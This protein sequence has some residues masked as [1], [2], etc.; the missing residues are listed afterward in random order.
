MNLDPSHTP[1]INVGSKGI[2]KINVEGKKTHEAN[3][4]KYETVSVN[5]G[6]RR[7]S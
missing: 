4:R 2:K 7:A 3:R 6:Y 5:L 1:Y